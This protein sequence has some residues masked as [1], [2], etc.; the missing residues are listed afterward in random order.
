MFRRTSTLALG[1]LF[2]LLAG[3]AFGQDAVRADRASAK[4][5]S[6]W[7]PAKV[8]LKFRGSWLI[9]DNAVNT[10][11]VGIG[12]DYQSANPRYEVSLSFRPRYY[13]Y[14][15]DEHE[16]FVSGRADVIREITNNDATTREGET[17]LSDFTLFLADR[18]TL[19]GSKD[20]WLLAQAPIV[21]FPTSTFSFDNGT[22]LGLGARAWFN[23]SLTLAGDAWS[24][25]KRVHTGLIVSYNHTFTQA[26]TA[27]N[28]ELRRVRL[29]PDGRTYPGDQLTGAAFPNHELRVGALLITEITDKLQLWLDGSYRPTWLY[30]FGNAEV[31]TQTG[32]APVQAEQG[33]TNYVVT[34][35]FGANLYYD[36]IPE[37]TL[38][39]GYDN[40]ALQ[41]GPDGQRRSFFH[42]P[43][44]QFHFVLWAH[45]DAIYLA[46]TGQR[47]TGH[48]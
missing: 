33:S 24:V 27:T 2:L 10:Q 31:C 48:D 20:T 6:T 19:G 38:G 14:E 46:A 39:A 36:M 4:G 7:D 23:Q 11:T 40:I 8:R 41:L 47:A 12:S 44:A 17:T 45:L 9:L 26:T 42:S 43:G 32:C 34:T 18:I 1:A 30:S 21:T 13:L 25:F 5:K 35:S 3:S 15:S 22:V 29:E 28:A 37:L 16:V